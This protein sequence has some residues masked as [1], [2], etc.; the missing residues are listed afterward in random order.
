MTPT[1][2]KPSQLETVGLRA[3]SGYFNFVVVPKLFL[4]FGLSPGFCF[5]E[6]SSY[7]LRRRGEE[8]DCTVKDQSILFNCN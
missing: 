8:L 2:R 6:I 5:Y 4:L 7:V 1:N 3:F